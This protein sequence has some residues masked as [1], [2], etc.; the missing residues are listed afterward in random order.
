VADIVASLEGLPIDEFFE[1]SYKQLLLRNPEYL[2]DVGLAEAYGLRHDQLNDL[3]DAYIRETQQLESAILNLLR[4][5]D[6]AMLTPDQQIS[7][8]VYEWYL[9]DLVRGHEFM[10]HNYPVTHF[11]G[12][13]DDELIR[14]LTELHPLD[15]QQDAEDYI[16]RLS[17][18][19]DQA[20]QLLD[21]LKRREELGIIPP[22]FIVGMALQNLGGIANNSPRYTPFYTAFDEKLQGI[23]GLGEPEKQALLEA[24]ETEIAESVIPGFRAL[25]DY[26]TTLQASTTDDEG[27]W[28]FPN[29]DAYYAYILRQQASVDI[30]P[31]EVHE[32]GLAEVERIQAEMRQAFDELGYP[33]GASLGDLMNRAIEDG[34]FYDTR[35]QEGKEQVVKAFEDL[36][37]E[38]DQALDAV[39]DI[40]PKAEVVVVGGP[41]GGFYVPGPLDGSRP[42]AFHASTGGSWT[43][44]FNMPTIAYHEAIPGHHFQ[45]AIAQEMD[46][47]LFRNDVFFNG[48][49]EGW[50]LYAER[51]AWELGLYDDD[52]YGNLG[53]LQLELLRAIRLV[54][55]TGIHAKQWTRVE[56]KAYMNEAL[57]D[58]SGRWSHEV[59]RYIV[60][61]AQATGYKIGMLKILELRQRAMDELGDEFDIKEFHN[62]LLGS[63]SMP[64]DILERVVQDYIDA[65]LGK[66]S[67]QA[68]YEP[69]FEPDIC[70]FTPPY[71]YEV[72]CGYLVVPENRSKPDS[73]SIRV[74]VAIFKSTNPD[75]KP[76]P[77]IYVAGGGGVNQLAFSERYLNN[78]G[79]DILRDRDYIMYNQRGAHLNEPSL[80]CPDDTNLFWSLAKQD[81][82]PHERDDREIAKR[83]ECHDAL[84]EK[85]IDL[86]AY[87]TVETAADVN[88]LRIA[89]GYEKIN[90]YGT[91][92]GTRTILTIMRN[93]PE[94]IRSVILDSVYPPQVGLYSTVALSVDRVFSLLFETCAAD[95]DC[96]QK[97]PDLEA[98]FYQTVDELNANPASVQ[99]SRGT[100]LVDG[101]FFM[102]AVYMNFYSTGAIPRLPAWIQAASQGDFTGLKGT[103]EGRLTDTGTLIAIGFEWS[104]Q[105]NEEVPFE[106]YEL[107][108]ELAVDLPPQIAEYFDSYY[109]FT[110]C[111]SWQAGQADPVENTAVV[112]DLP[113]LILA[114]Q[115]DPVTPPE[116]SQLA[117]ETLGNHF[118]YEF[119]GYGHGIMRSDRCGLEIG[120]QFLEDPT[121]EPDAS[122]MDEL[123]GLQFP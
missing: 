20:E 31:E 55:D 14:L 120:L 1:E 70:H 24:A 43:P 93:H 110:L 95:P 38:A 4:G 18:V 34:G 116:W 21:G 27:V 32:L 105:C 22:K 103:F 45:I 81:L 28:K 115:F 84:L 96:N 111:E 33:Q 7:Y 13:W 35:T 88:D 104:L 39:V 98:T 99:L 63:G 94:G 112:S 58:P 36:L 92:S 86:T 109:E 49:G 40:R 123:S 78:G 29:G 23:E 118:Y 108:R 15:D 19:D 69:V 83:L 106:S 76:D 75:P 47:P 44:K 42:G 8:D 2:T 73:P 65:K 102:E 48:Y 26:F 101:G 25:T 117:A 97:Y 9:D 41:Y 74:H 37:D 119:P 11:L 113:A 100:V 57:G 121:S 91:S 10:Y 17:Q 52:P 5:Y 114:G 60:M 66:A 12:S 51:L 61:P 79:N 6:R 50:A 85:G 90:L 30:T 87:N 72:E 53:R 3:S 62:L 59:E 67:A 54:V 16:S 68:S 122:C 82:A 80:V 89:L 107:G 64:L 77:V 46:V 71:G 56:S